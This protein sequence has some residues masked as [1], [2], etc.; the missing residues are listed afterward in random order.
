[1]PVT[2]AAES[3]ANTGNQIEQAVPLETLE[4]IISSDEFGGEKDG[5][6]IRLKNPLEPKETPEYDLSPWM[7][8]IKIFF[9][10]ALRVILVLL[11]AAI[12]VLVFIYIYKNYHPKAHNKAKAKISQRFNKKGESAE[13]LLEKSQVCYKNGEIRSAWAYCFAAALGFWE[14]YQNIIFPGTAT[15]YE[16]LSIVRSAKNN[17]GEKLSDAKESEFAYL[18]AQWAGLAYGGRLP[19]E[20]AFEKAITYCKSLELHHAQ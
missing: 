17:S 1:M 2:A 12:A 11:I 6:G 4:E 13:L 5:W 7:E 3:G 15:E 18:V 14:Q 20:E 8:K 9:A 19:G 10:A 16:C